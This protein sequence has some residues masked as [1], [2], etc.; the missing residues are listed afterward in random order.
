MKI[1]RFFNS[2]RS[3]ASFACSDKLLNLDTFVGPHGYLEATCHGGAVTL[4]S[5][6]SDVTLHVP[7][8]TIQ[9]G[10]AAWVHTNP[11]TFKHLL[12]NRECLVSP[13]VMFGPKSPTDPIT[14]SAGQ[15]FTIQI[16]HVIPNVVDLQS[17]IRVRYGDIHGPSLLMRQAYQR[18]QASNQGVSY[19]VNDTHI[20]VYSRHLTGFVVT[21]A[22]DYC[23]SKESSIR[24][25]GA[26]GDTGLCL[27][28]YM[29]SSLYAIKDFQEVESLFLNRIRHCPI[30]QIN[31]VPLTTSKKMQKKLLVISGC[32]L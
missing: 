14:C 2:L 17:R 16:P 23:F 8:N 5:P 13:I 1:K 10:V 21:L 24:V 27:K 31:W 7:M 20:T 3:L 11:T 9:G 32:S 26:L 18:G 19:Q 12:P 22:R 4:S 30:W 6:D 25:F 28:A 15:Y 29:C